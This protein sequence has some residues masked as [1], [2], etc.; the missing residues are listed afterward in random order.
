[1]LCAWCSRSFLDNSS[2][3]AAVQ[4]IT[5]KIGCTT[6]TLCNW[7]WPHE[8]DIGQRGAFVEGLGPHS[9]CR[10]SCTARPSCFRMLRP[11]SGL[12]RRSN[13]IAIALDSQRHYSLRCDP[14]EVPGRAATAPAGDHR[15]SIEG[16]GP[17]RFGMGRWTTGR[18]RSFFPGGRG[19]GLSPRWNARGRW[20]R[21]TAAFRC[22]GEHPRRVTGWSAR[23]R[24]ARY[25]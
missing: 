22:W 7:A 19:L 5:P 17:I 16:N 23:K 20:S 4:A 1:M 14:L 8:P 24:T 15:G 11:R 6:Q 13:L 10:K 3:W 18:S 9:F 21:R 25:G 2:Q 12:T